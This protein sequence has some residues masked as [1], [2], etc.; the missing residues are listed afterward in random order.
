VAPYRLNSG[1]REKTKL[2]TFIAT[3]KRRKE[4]KKVKG[5]K[6]RFGE[7][8][9]AARKTISAAINFFPPNAFF[10]RR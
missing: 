2:C 1:Q 8:R 4:R 7:E 5:K 10:I 9:A 6:K 3:H